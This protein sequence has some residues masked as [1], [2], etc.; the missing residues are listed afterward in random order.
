M[1]LLEILRCNISK[2]TIF[3]MQ[4]LDIVVEP[5]LYRLVKGLI[6]LWGAVNRL[7]VSNCGYS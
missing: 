6:G 1:E 5:L 2:A 4:A 3:Q 7:V